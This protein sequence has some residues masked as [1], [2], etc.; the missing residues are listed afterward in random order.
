MRD[1]LR[2]VTHFVK[3]RTSLRNS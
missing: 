3:Q 1:R 2:L